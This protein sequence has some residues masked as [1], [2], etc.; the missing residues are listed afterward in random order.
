QPLLA[1]IVVGDGAGAIGRAQRAGVD[2]GALQSAD[3]SARGGD[4]GVGGGLGR[5]LVVVPARALLDRAVAAFVDRAGDLP[6]HPVVGDGRL[7]E[8]GVPLPHQL[9]AAVVLVLPG[10]LVGIG[11]RLLVA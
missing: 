6:A 3:P 10:A 11:E 1:L 8:L 9:A 2:L 7:V 4:H 5:G